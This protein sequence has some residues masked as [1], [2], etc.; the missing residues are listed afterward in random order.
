M[1][2]ANLTPPPASQ[3]YVYIR[4][5][6]Q[7]QAWGDDE[8]RQHDAAMRFVETHG[9]PVAETLQDIG[10]SAFRGDNA[11]TG[12]LGSFLKPARHLARHD[13]AGLCQLALRLPVR[14]R[15]K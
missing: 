7:S 12:S 10:V 14:Q 8:R 4:L 5:S 15:P 13:D 3:A 11:S 1:K 9:L 6:S 2:N